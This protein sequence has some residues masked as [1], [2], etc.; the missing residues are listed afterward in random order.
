M[1]KKLH[2][3]RKNIR[4]FLFRWTVLVIVS[5]VL[6]GLLE[7]AHLPAALLLGP[8]AAGIFL[9]T[10]GVHFSIYRPLFNICQGI[11]GI[12][13]AHQLPMDVLGEIKGDWPV[14][15]AGTMSTILT[16]G[17][18]GWLLAKSAL[19]PGTTAIWG[20]SPGAATVMTLMCEDYGADMR[21]VAFMQYFRVVCCALSATLVA[22]L[23]AGA[24]HI[25][26]VTN[27]WGEPLSWSFA[28]TLAL[29]VAGVMAGV[30]LK[31]PGGALVVP[32][33][34]GMAVNF[35][36][37]MPLVLP[38]WFLA[39]AYAIIGWGI[40]F[41]FT[42]KVLKHAA[43]LFPYIFGAILALLSANAVV[44]LILV[45]YV[46][47]DLLSAFLATSPGGLDSVAII[48]AATH[49]N[50]PFVM[51]MQVARFFLVIL[52]GPLLARWLSVSKTAV[53]G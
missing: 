37:K 3:R 10:R 41:R 14:F 20:S 46:H 43:H 42:R 23:V 26:H 45:R 18:L 31:I 4:P 49:V 8:M 39:L 22:W 28:G 38:P 29:V 30:K 5:L 9:V 33:C 40:G 6:V 34:L 19:L 47:V 12:M 35:S 27:W 50:L 25:S 7:W 51:S 36:V 52:A 48:A 24:G 17:F 2:V 11:V 44:A 32:M 21:L 1:T 15:L 53:G 16:S 13:I